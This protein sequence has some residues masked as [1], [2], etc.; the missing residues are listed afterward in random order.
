[1]VLYVGC[2][3]SKECGSDE[4]CVNKE[5]V[6]VGY[7]CPGIMCWVPILAKFWSPNSDWNELTWMVLPDSKM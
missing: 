4:I 1:M 6:C 7:N 5:C 3:S 2:T